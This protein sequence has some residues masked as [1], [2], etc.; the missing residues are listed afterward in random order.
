MRLY[1]VQHGEAVAEATDPDRPLTQRGRD[2]V[3]RTAVWLGHCGVQVQ[4]VFHSGKTRARQTAE[5]LASSVCRKTAP[6]TLNGIRP[7]DDLPPFLQELSGW[8]KD[9]LVVGHLPFLAKVV[10]R[11]LCDREQTPWVT[12]TPGT[13]VCLERVSENGWTLRWMLPPELA[14]ACP[15]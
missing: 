10:T 14:P 3:H 15:G 1:L 12:F 13:L 9:T 7:R 11:L 4:R 2:E 8:D 6:Q 5:L